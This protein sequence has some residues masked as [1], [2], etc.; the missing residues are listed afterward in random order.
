MI[1]L[2]KI[3][4]FDLIKLYN[5]QA[6]ISLEEIKILEIKFLAYIAW[7]RQYSRIE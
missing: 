1:G 5:K 4:S 7:K 6:L 3:I 2:N